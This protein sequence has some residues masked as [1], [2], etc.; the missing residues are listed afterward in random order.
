MTSKINEPEYKL[1]ASIKRRCLPSDNQYTKEQEVGMYSEWIKDYD[2][3]KKDI[4]NKPTKDHYFV[5]IDTTKGFTPDNVKWTTKK[6][7][8]NINKYW[9]TYNNIKESIR[10]WSKVTGISYWTLL[11]RKKARWED[12]YIIETKPVSKEKKNKN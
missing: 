4:G 10:Y 6:P 7:G 2:K 3:F 11:Q 9:I 12:K 8:N 5:R 1:W